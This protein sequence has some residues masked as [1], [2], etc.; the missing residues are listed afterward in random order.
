MSFLI[1]DL[2]GSFQREFKQLIEDLI[3]L[4]VVMVTSGGNKCSEASY[5]NLQA[6]YDVQV[7]VR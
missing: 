2:G 7:I 5:N 4:D 3:D 6:L 1:G